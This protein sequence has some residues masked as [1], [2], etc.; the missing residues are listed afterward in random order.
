MSKFDA[1]RAL[2]IYKTFTKQTNLV[3]DFL[4]TARHYENA[5][6]LEIPKL[7][8]AP[9]SL[10]SSLEEY[11]NDPDFEVNRRQYLAH[12]DA[13]KGRKPATNGDAS[14]S[15]VFKKQ[16]VNVGS[17]SNSFPEPKAT[18]PSAPPHAAAKGPAPDLIDFFDSIEQN[19]QPMAIQSQQQAPNFQSTQPP[20]FAPQQNFYAQ[21]ALQ[22]QG[23]QPNGGTFGDS[24]PFGQP[25][26]QQ[27]LQQ[28]FTGTGFGGYTP[29]P[30]SQQQDAFSNNSQ[31]TGSSVP[32]QQQPFSTGQTSFAPTQ[33]SFSTGQSQSTNPFRQSIFP[34]ATSGSTPSYSASPPM[35]QPQILQ[36]TNPFARTSTAQSSSPF[37]QMPN[38][39]SPFTSQ[40]PQ[41]SQAIPFTSAPLQ[42][43]Q[44]AP[45]MHTNPQR[46]GTNPF[47]RT[48]AP[49]SQ[50]QPPAQPLVASAT[51]TN[52]F[53]QSMFT[54]QQGSQGWQAG[55][56]TMGGLEHLETMPVFPRSGQQ[57]Q[58]TQ[59]AQSP[60]P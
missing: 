57:L 43:P 17:K 16:A 22:P 26:Q 20:D 5:T 19:Q 47:A 49:T 45:A 13:K 4:G 50:S 51:G 25:Q 48:A 14:S 21:T 38:Q 12:Q 18:Q 44:Q 15:D 52:P 35:P 34:Q 40:P 46:T 59:Q 2:T 56:G 32:S 36:S 41:Q 58:Q 60:W 37:T 31:P 3:V 53:R 7:K 8:H 23:P 39:T 28:N 30:F 54:N 6:R 11:L 42:Q 27:P 24:N 55:Q 1:Q 9:T 29:Q 10:T 33:Q